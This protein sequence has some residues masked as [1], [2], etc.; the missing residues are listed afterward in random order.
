MLNNLT[1]RNL[2]EMNGFSVLTSL[3]YTKRV[4]IA[5]NFPSTSIIAIIANVN[6]K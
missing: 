6:F 5:A 3:K 2:T 4:K 1:E